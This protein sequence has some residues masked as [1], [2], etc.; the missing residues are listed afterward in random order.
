MAPFGPSALRRNFILLFLEESSFNCWLRD[1][2][3]IIDPCSLLSPTS[4][5]VHT[6]A[7]R[8]GLPRHTP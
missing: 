3:D 8:L 2:L 1:R 7:K 4:K 5:R 6:F